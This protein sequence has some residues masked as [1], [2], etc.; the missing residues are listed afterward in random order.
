MATAEALMTI[1]ETRSSLYY[2]L[3]LDPDQIRPW[4][5]A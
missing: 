5:E 1:R 2:L 3:V 4:V